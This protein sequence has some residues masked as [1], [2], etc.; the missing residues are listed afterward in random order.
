MRCL[1]TA[2]P[3]VGFFPVE[4]SAAVHRRQRKSPPQAFPALR[5][6]LLRLWSGRPAHALAANSTA[7]YIAVLAFH[8]SV[9]DADALRTLPGQLRQRLP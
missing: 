2:T 7:G 8:K 4:D 5:T 3:S 1:M 6:G 9:A